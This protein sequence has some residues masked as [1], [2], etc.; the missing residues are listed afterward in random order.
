MHYKQILDIT[1]QECSKKG[2]T[3][4]CSYFTIQSGNGYVG[5][6]TETADNEVKKECSST[7]TTIVQSNI[8]LKRTV[9]A[10]NKT[11]T[12]NPPKKNTNNHRRCYNLVSKHY[13]NRHVIIKCSCIFAGYQNQAID[14]HNPSDAFLELMF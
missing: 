12:R 13:T 3:I 4:Q 11:F 2:G 1:R 8:H 6:K 7:C 9:Q 5:K 10:Y 14:P